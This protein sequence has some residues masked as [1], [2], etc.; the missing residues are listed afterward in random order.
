[1]T[2]VDTDILIDLFHG[3]A[4][5]FE[6]IA[7]KLASDEETTISVVTLTELLGGMRS[8]EE[9]KTEN[10]LDMFRVL[11]IDEAIGRK[12]AHYL[13]L[14]RRTH[15]IDLG[16]AFV[17]ATAAY[18]EATVATRN[19]RHYPMKDEILMLIPYERGRS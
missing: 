13:R 12:A 4:K 3:N 9:E 5:A 8:G 7:S 15:R 11:H 17:A 1:M 10:L 2:I 14:Y 16:D 19:A 18:Y 6:F